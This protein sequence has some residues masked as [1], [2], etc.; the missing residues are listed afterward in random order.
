MPELAMEYCPTAVTDDTTLP[1]ARLVAAVA[2]QLLPS[3]VVS[4]VSVAEN[5]LATCR[6]TDGPDT[7]KIAQPVTVA[8]FPAS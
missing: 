8:Q 2:T 3:L 4:T 5:V 1:S 7:A 6:V